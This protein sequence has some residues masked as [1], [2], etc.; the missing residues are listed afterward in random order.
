M[1]EAQL[2]QEK[3]QLALERAKLEREKLELEQKKLQRITIAV[4][5]VAVVVSLLQ[6][7]VGWL[8]SRLATAQTVEKF[9]PHL[10]KQDTRDAALLTMSSFVDQRFVTQL[11]EKLKA[12]TVLEALQTKGSAQDQTQATQALSALD[13]QRN[14]LIDKL[15]D[16]DKP[17]RIAATTELVRQWAAD[18][19]LVPQLIEVAGTRTANQSGTINA[20]VVLRE[21]PAENLRANA[22][23]LGPLLDKARANGPQTAALVAEVQQRSSA[24]PTKP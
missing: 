15:F 2:I 24:P 4:S 19:K 17:V 10:Q 1:T 3:E 9:I 12:T 11:A 7:L 23:D 21:V 8:Q 14:A 13:L 22:A 6:V 18:P 16:A 20:L 5:T